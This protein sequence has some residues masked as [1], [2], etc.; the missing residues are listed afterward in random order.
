MSTIVSSSTGRRGQDHF[1][2]EATLDP[3][4]QRRLRGHLEQVDFTAFAANCE[5]LRKT[6]GHTD[7]GK[8][9]R[10]AAAGAHARAQW[11]AAA[12]AIS[13]SSV[14]PTPAQIQQLN[15]LRRSFEELTQA[16][17]A[18]RRMVERGYLNFPAKP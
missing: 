2:P 11:V 9:Q 7:I 16:Y 6:L 15:V 18:M 12:L 4:E 10:L 8:F 1:Q 3:Q 17:E 5:V 14:S 13:E